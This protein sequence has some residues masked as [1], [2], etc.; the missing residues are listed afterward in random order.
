MTITLLIERNVDKSNYVRKG[1]SEMAMTEDFV[2]NAVICE[3]PKLGFAATDIKTARE[4]GVDIVAKNTKVSRYFLIEAKGDPGDEVKSLPAG[5]EVRFLQ[6]VGQLVTRIHPERG[7]YYGLAYPMSFKTL[8]AR[9]LCPGLL[10]KLQIH[11]FFVETTRKV[12]HL[13][14]R[15]LRNLQA[16]TVKSRSRCGRL[17]E[18]THTPARR[19]RPPESTSS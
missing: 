19:G 15:D 12:E 11:L 13:T 4:H 17:C 6:S 5:R 7:Y 8:V 3:L 10:K 18:N 14:W 2:K 16:S 1:A 9:R